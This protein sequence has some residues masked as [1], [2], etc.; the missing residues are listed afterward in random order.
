M[1]HQQA[2]SLTP[3]LDFARSTEHDERVL[4]AVS[5]LRRAEFRQ[6]VAL[7]RVQPKAGVPRRHV[8]WL[9]GVRPL[10]RV[11]Y[12]LHHFRPRAGVAAVARG[13]RDVLAALSND[14]ETQGSQSVRPVLKHW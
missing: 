4:Q 7:H 2:G 3:P 5:A 8:Y 11:D 9:P 12:P 13:W 1:L 6:P 14:G 10:D